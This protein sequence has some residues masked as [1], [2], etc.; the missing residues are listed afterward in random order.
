MKTGAFGHQYYQVTRNEPE[1][2]LLNNL[3]TAVTMVVPRPSIAIDDVTVIEGDLGTTNAEFTVRLS[4]PS[5]QV[6]TVQ[7][8]TTEDTAKETS[9]YIGA[10][11]LLTFQPGV[12][13]QKVVVQVKGEQRM[14][15]MNNFSDSLVA[16]K[17][18]VNSR[19][20]HC[21]NP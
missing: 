11:G 16:G 13:T 14:S 18:F 6:I 20:C 3:S 8:A 12:T 19:P 15:R 5:S 21:I 10:T 2:Y 1:D 17:R 9:D 7:Y 4:G